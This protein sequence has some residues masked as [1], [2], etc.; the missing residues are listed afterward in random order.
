[1][2]ATLEELTDKLIN[3]IELKKLETTSRMI[4]Q[5]TSKVILIILFEFS[6]CLCVF[7]DAFFSYIYLESC[8][9]VQYQF[10]RIQ[11]WL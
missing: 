9:L 6:G 8:I 1:M 11:L 4:N 3:I 5:L 7:I 2:N 10:P